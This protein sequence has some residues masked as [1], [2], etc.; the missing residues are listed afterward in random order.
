MAAAAG[1]AVPGGQRLQQSESI[2]TRHTPPPPFPAQVSLLRCDTETQ[3]RE[4]HAGLRGGR[5]PAAAEEEEVAAAAAQ[6]EESEGASDVEVHAP[7]PLPHPPHL[8]PSVVGHGVLRLGG[9]GARAP[10]GDPALNAMRAHRRR[11]ARGSG[12]RRRGAAARARAR[13]QAQAQARAQTGSTSGTFSFSR[14][15]GESPGR[16]RH[17]GRGGRRAAAPLPWARARARAPPRRR[18]CWCSSPRAVALRQARLG[19]H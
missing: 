8:Q 1:F 15:P 3:L 17:S 11:L 16:S 6:S 5:V 2:P 14:V 7:P 9:G 19:R 13:A 12:A 18:R 10:A 4:V